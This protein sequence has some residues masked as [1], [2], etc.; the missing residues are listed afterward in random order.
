MTLDPSRQSSEIRANTNL[1]I[2][3]RRFR[4]GV[5]VITEPVRCAGGN[6]AADEV[7]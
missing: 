7:G 4:A 6:V 2:A 1:R 5:A 3:L